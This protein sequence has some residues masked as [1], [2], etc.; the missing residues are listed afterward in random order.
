MEKLLIE[1]LSD[2]FP[3]HSFSIVR[4]E[5]GQETFG[6]TQNESLLIDGKPLGLS[7]IPF[8]SELT[9]KQFHS[10]WLRCLPKVRKIIRKREQLKS[11][12]MLN[13]VKKKYGKN[14]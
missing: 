3:A 10:L 7:W 12:K 6:H 2:T 5:L 13:K 14:K 1:K 9:E 8:L 4:M 11:T